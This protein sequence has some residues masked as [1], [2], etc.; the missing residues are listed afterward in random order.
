[1]PIRTSLLIISKRGEP[2]IQ[3][4]VD[5]KDTAFDTLA[6]YKA[7]G[8]GWPI[9]AIERFEAGEVPPRP[10]KQES[11]FATDSYSTGQGD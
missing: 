1:M 3:M 10:A 11:M 7:N 8:Y 5:D 9:W 6:H 2:D 4:V